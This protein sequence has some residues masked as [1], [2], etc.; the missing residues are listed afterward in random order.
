VVA[1]A[2][3]ALVTPEERYVGRRRRFFAGR[4]FAQGGAQGAGAGEVDVD[5]EAVAADAGD[6]GLEDATV[7]QAGALREAPAVFGGL[8]LAVDAVGDRPAEGR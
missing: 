7:G 6:E 5:F 3:L 1:E 8:G 4:D 2:G